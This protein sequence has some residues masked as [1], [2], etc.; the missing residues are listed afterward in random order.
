MTDQETLFAAGLS[1]Q[2]VALAPV[3][4]VLRAI[5]QL[6]VIHLQQAEL[7]EVGVG[8]APATPQIHNQPI[9]QNPSQGTAVALLNI[10]FDVGDGNEVLGF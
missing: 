2:R 1:K 7:L 10:G 5:H 9:L 8:K 3:R 6:G 4:L